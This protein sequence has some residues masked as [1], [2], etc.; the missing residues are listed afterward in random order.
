MMSLK[1]LLADD[2]R[3]I[4]ELTS[5]VLEQLGHTVKTVTDGVDVIRFI[6]AFPLPDLLITDY[7]MPRMDGLEVLRHIRTNERFKLLRVIV[8]TT[9]DYPEFKSVVEA[10]GG[11]LVNPKTAYNLLAAVDAIDKKLEKERR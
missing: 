11:V 8:Y 9:N 4:R 10:L 2:S 5:H 3:T 1:I 6:E 7:D